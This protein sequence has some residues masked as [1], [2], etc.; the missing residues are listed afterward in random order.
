[1]TLAGVFDPLPR[2]TLRAIP[3]LKALSLFITHPIEDFETSS[4]WKRRCWSQRTLTAHPFVNPPQR[5]EITVR[6]STAAQSH[7][8][9]VRSYNERSSCPS[10]FHLT[11]AP[12][13]RVTL[14]VHP[15]RLSPVRLTRDPN[16]PAG[17]FRG[18][19]AAGEARG[20]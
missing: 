7:L 13:P 17:F 3:L 20:F 4:N 2:D 5:K 16:L 6:I 19:G 8:C 1:M 15:G 14:P 11:P 12:A 10:A 18:G 9:A